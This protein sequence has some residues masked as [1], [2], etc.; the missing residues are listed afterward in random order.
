MLP[1]MKP[2]QRSKYL[3][4]VTRA[5]SKMFE[6]SLPESQHLALRADTDPAQLLVLTVGMLGDAAARENDSA[7][8]ALV[9]DTPEL[10]EVDFCA[11]F[12]DSYLT[13]KFNEEVSAPTALLAA[14]SFMLASRPGSA[15]LIAKRLHSASG[16]VFPDALRWVLHGDWSSEPPEI[17]GFRADQVNE[18]CR[19]LLA[20]F[21]DGINVEV[22]DGAFL[23]LRRV[24]YQSAAP[25]D[26]LF[27]DLLVATSRRR[28]AHSSRKNLPRYTA[29][30][31]S[32][33][34]APIRAGKIPAE[35]WPSQ[36][37]LGEFGVLSGRSAFVQ[38][39][40]SAGKTKAVEIV[41]RAGF[42]TNRAKLAVFVAPFRS[43]SHEVSA[44]L[45]TAFRG[46]STRVNELTDVMQADFL[47]QFGEL[48]GVSNALESNVLV[49]TPEKFVYVLRQMPSLMAS[50]DIVVL[51]EAHQF[52][53]G[54]RG[55]VYELLLTEIRSQLR[56]SVQ[57]VLVSAV[58]RNAPE[59]ASWIIGDSDA[60]IAPKGLLPTKRSIAF[61]SWKDTL[62]RLEFLDSPD[63]LR[64][65]FFVPRVLETVTLQKRG[66][67]RKLRQFPERDSST[68][69][70]LALGV[71]L[72]SQGAVAIFCGR[73]DT[74]TGLAARAVDVYSRGYPIAAPASYSD[75]AELVCLTTL[76]DA[77]FGTNSMLGEAAKL[78]ILVHHGQTPEGIRHSIEYGMQRGLLK[79]VICTST[80]AQGVN[81]PLR[82]LLVAATYQGGDAIKTRDF[83]NLIGR[84]G[85]AGMHTEGMIVF[86][87]PSI[88]DDRVRQPWKFI[89]SRALLS[90][91]NSEDSTSSI[92][93]LFAGFENGVGRRVALFTSTQLV[94]LLL[95][96]ESE[97]DSW[98]TEYGPRLIDLGI[99]R[100]S[101]FL[102]LRQRRALLTT[103]ESYLMAN[104]GDDSF[105]DFRQR[106]VALARGSLAYHLANGDLKAAIELLFLRV[107]E[108]IEVVE[109]SAETQARFARTLLGVDG[110]WRIRGWVEANRR[111]LEQERTPEAWLERIWELLLATTNHRLLSDTAPE[112]AV[113]RITILW[114]RGA[115]YAELYRFASS[116]ETSKP[117]GKGRRAL[118]L[119][120][121]VALC[122]SAISFQCS[123]VV[124][125]I[126]EL[127]FGAESALPSSMTFRIFQ[128]SLQYGLPNELAIA[129][130]EAGYCDRVIAQA[131]ASAV[132]ANGYQGDSFR[133]ARSTH[134][135]AI[136][137]VLLPYPSYFR[138]V[139]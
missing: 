13:S 65:S 133:D 48:L 139:V 120:D 23:A 55:V 73:R 121:I 82:Y 53:S 102:E 36:I 75:P 35:L 138:Q 17:E 87:D 24:C 107:A 15:S 58:V 119:E 28:L 125:A 71:R 4:S 100:G 137:T 60:V 38:M 135:T 124:G 90:Q 98:L 126:N 115:T 12:F 91:E 79:F 94:D 9:R 11:S 101:L 76:C 30:G 18:A 117:W 29:A 114:M 105:P 50:V 43:L 33:W 84:A 127:L 103:I 3:L 61:A 49:M 21:R 83:Q 45:R 19:V 122:E 123:L 108:Y 16:Q 118:T 66:K 132:Q 81:L 111:E 39:P 110:A 70:A 40:T 131:V 5:K 44:S 56:P 80:L 42:A 59:L 47:S 8:T 7:L 2:E 97:W 25:S 64:S 57:V 32:Y 109:P 78:G 95:Q 116:L 128:K 72:V 54:S 37:R 104:R 85:R 112:G 63:D 136:E 129:A 1:A 113:Q 134:S 6:F 106:V 52:D 67:E 62:G 20:H 130:F 74:A 51:D 34:D 31:E 93:S 86:T 68:D 27:C 92:F 99:E 14:S 10:E 41:L 46:E 96:T 88:Y 26:L 77:H 89:R 22:P 69:I